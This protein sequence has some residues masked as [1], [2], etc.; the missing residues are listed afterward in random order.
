MQDATSTSSGAVVASSDATA[1]APPAST[2]PIVQPA[3][4]RTTGFRATLSDYVAISKTRIMLLLVMVAWAAMFVAAGGLPAWKPLLAVTVAG[5]TSTAAAGAF[6]NI[7][8]RG[9][10]SR[11]ERTKARPVASGRLS[12]MEA[13]IYAVGMSIVAWGALW[14]PGYRLASY[15]T[16]GAIA[17]YSIVYTLLLKPSTPQNIVIGGLAGSFPAVI[18][19]TAVTLSLAWPASWPALVI[20]GIVFLWTPAHFWALALLYKD[21]YAAADYPMMPNI[22]GES[23]TRRQMLGYAILTLVAS[24]AIV[25]TGDAGWIY[26]I[27]AVGLGAVLVTRSWRLLVVHS[28]GKYRS[29]F[30]FTIQY[31]GFLLVALMVDRVVELPAVPGT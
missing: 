5:A 17:Y 27:A 6:N 10:D 29:F 26:L 15:L 16:L 12:V 22:K 31:L 23:S 7:F 1:P 13:T 2:T 20:A 21:D 19:W 28:A 18:G 24:L 9:R 14:F 4:P 11:M 30:F 3:P 25:A 8:E